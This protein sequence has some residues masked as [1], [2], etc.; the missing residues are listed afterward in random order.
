MI[1]SD[2][3]SEIPLKEGFD[4]LGGADVASMAPP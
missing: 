3:F 2:D 4:G 1:V